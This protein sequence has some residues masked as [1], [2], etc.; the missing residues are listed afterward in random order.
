MNLT[1]QLTTLQ[2]T[3]GKVRAARRD[4]YR[5]AKGS[6][7]W[8]RSRGTFL[9]TAGPGND[10]AE[11]NPEADC[12]EWDGTMREIRDLIAKVED[13]YPDVDLIYIAG[14]FDG[15]ETLRDLTDGNYEPWL[16]NWQVHVW[17]RGKGFV[18]D[19]D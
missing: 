19:G 10:Q 12:P 3:V 7:P 11:P 9:C 15:G 13:R 1:T 8:V 2:Q 16:S 17:R 5:E 14:G 6:M 4:A 18:L